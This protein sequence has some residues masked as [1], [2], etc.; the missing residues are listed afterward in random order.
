MRPGRA[1]EG[2]M[3]EVCFAIGLEAQRG[4]GPRSVRG[5]WPELGSQPPC[6]RSSES[7]RS[8]R[9]QV[10]SQMGTLRCRASRCLVRGRPGPSDWDARTPRSEPEAPQH[11]R[12]SRRNTLHSVLLGAVPGSFYFFRCYSLEQSRNPRPRAAGFQGRERGPSLV[13]ALRPDPA[14]PLLLPWSP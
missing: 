4:Y 9:P 11:D 7:R 3:E 6:R 8:P 2:F 10:M 1:P 13:P 5:T 14:R 12:R